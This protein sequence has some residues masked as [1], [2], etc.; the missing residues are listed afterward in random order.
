MVVIKIKGL[1]VLASTIRNRRLALGMTQAEL[2]AASGVSQ[3]MIVLVEKGKRLP[4]LINMVSIL[5][6]LNMT[7][8]IQEKEKEKV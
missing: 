7:L 4:H 8:S 1:E 6:A 2:S 3:P 5:S